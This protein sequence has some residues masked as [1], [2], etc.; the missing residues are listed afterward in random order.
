MPRLGHMPGACNLPYGALTNGD[1][2]MKSAEELR[3]AFENAGINP[4]KP[5]ITTCGSGITACI[6]ALGLAILGN[7]YTAVYDGSWAEWAAAP[8]AP[9]VT[10]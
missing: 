10:D 7:E 3:A 9:A 6:L 1:G 5:V 8:S 2:T 4:A